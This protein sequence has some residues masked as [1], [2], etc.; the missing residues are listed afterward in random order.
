MT[1]ALEFFLDL[2]RMCFLKE[3]RLSYCSVLTDVTDLL[4]PEVC[5]FTRD[6][7]SREN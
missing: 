3:K 6:A 1:L 2:F 4:V 5:V 7:E